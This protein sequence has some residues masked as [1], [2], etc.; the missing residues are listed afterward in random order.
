[1]RFHDIHIFTFS[2][3]EFAHL[4]ENGRNTTHFR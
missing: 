2:Q 1:M 4:V 3:L